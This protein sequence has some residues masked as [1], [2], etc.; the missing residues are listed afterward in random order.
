M[1]VI[2]PSTNIRILNN[3]KL[4]PSYANSIYFASTTAQYNYFVGKQKYNLANYTYQRVNLGVI[5][6]G[7]KAD[8]LYDC[9]YLMFQ[10]TNFGS[11][12]FYAFITSI[13]YVNNE[14]SYVTYQLDEVQTWLFEMTLMPCIIERTHIP[15]GQDTIGANLVAEPVQLG[16]Y[17]YTGQT[18]AVDNKNS[19]VIIQICDVE[20]V[21]TYGN[22]YDETFSGCSL[23]GYR[24]DTGSDVTP[25]ITK[26]A[27]YSQKPDAVVGMYTIPWWVIRDHISQSTHYLTEGFNGEYK[28][29]SYTAISG[30]ESFG[31]YTPRNKKLYTYPFNFARFGTGDGQTMSMRY[32][33]CKNNTPQ[34]YVRCNATCPVQI[35]ARPI[36][37]KGIE[38]PSGTTNNNWQNF[39]M[40]LDVSGFPL[41]SWTNDYYS[42]WI[43]QNAL[44]LAV[45]TGFSL[46]GMMAGAMTP[47]YNAELTAAGQ[48]TQ[49]KIGHF[50]DLD[51]TKAKHSKWF[52]YSPADQENGM[53][54]AM[55]GVPNAVTGLQQMY[56]ASIHADQFRG[57]MNNGNVNHANGTNNIYATRVHIT[58]EMCELIDNYFDKYG[59]AYGR[60]GTPNI[61]VRPKWTYV[62]TQGCIIKGNCPANSTAFVESLYDRG[63]TFWADGDE[64]G[65]YDLASQN[66]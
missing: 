3:V 12:W 1:A 33:F 58:P 22:R 4:D 51:P 29:Y 56:M 53:D 5:R 49:S 26:L 23:F 38:T 8:L 48:V 62:K 27:E 41:C 17:V 24:C 65:R 32:E 59:Y 14:T 30:N 31:S 19:G 16:E 2:E 52:N 64:I 45:G 9:N 39:D 47:S 25:I 42:T 66:R 60:V 61:H 40:E 18:V 50:M 13:E 57:T 20:D 11:K 55:K 34:I 43:A 10:N 63:I 21:T 28:T 46:A 15:A 6:V 35:T 44:P 54:V 36:N 7:I 37:Y